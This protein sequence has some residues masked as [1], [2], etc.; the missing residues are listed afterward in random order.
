M[1]A[2]G[3]KFFISPNEIIDHSP[4]GWPV[5][6]NWPFTK[7]FDQILTRAVEHGF[8]QYWTLEF[9]RGRWGWNDEAWKVMLL[10]KIVFKITIKMP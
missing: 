4:V 3:L 6:K 7:K 8:V 9:G 5:R 10:S 2:K 1:G